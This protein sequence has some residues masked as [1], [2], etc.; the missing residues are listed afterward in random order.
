MYE[1]F[2]IAVGLLLVGLGATMAFFGL[3][4]LLAVIAGALSLWGLLAAPALCVGGLMLA[5]FGF[6]L[7]MFS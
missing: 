6:D 7:F 3:L 1:H 4:T 2:M 5:S